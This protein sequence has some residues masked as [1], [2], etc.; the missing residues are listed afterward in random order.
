MNTQLPVNTFKQALRE[1]RPQIGLWASL[2]SNIA[3]EVI[4][5]SGF[6][7]ILIDTEHAPNELPL[8]F[9]QFPE[10]VSSDQAFLFAA[11]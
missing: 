5:G 9:S 1:A 7:W 6:D 11:D 8:V 2:C 10:Q 3:A 4:A